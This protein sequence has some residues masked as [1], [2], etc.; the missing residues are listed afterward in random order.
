MNTGL[1][2]S[3]KEHLDFRVGAL[4]NDSRTF[5]WVKCHHGAKFSE[6]KNPSI[7][8]GNFLI[9][10]GSFAALNLLA[11]IYWIL[12]KDSKDYPFIDIEVKSKFSEQKKRLKD[13][14][15]NHINEFNIFFE[16]CG[17]DLREGHFI[18]EKHAF[19]KLVKDLH[20]D[21]IDLGLGED[22]NTINKIWEDLRNSPAHIAIPQGKVGGVYPSNQ[23][24]WRS[25]VLKDLE[26][27]YKTPFIKQNGETFPVAE[28]LNEYVLKIKEWIFMKIDSQSI[29]E[30]KIRECFKLLKIQV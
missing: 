23:V 25:S 26:R 27:Q 19:Y 17:A 8:G 15:K 9:T 2:R 22:E 24:H 6:G 12:S 5:L 16:Y 4:V 21:K 14:M 20:K 10:L 11:K 30:Q 18:R 3:L 1:K 7:G 28:L 29:P 13:L